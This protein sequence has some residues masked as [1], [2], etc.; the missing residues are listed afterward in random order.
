MLQIHWY[1]SVLE[2]EWRSDLVQLLGYCVTLY[3]GVLKEINMP[4]QTQPPNSSL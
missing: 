2:Q 3:I 1:N 4:D